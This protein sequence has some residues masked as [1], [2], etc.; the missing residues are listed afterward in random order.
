MLRCFLAYCRNTNAGCAVAINCKPPG[1]ALEPLSKSIRWRP[2]IGE[3]VGA[4]ELPTLA[5]RWLSHTKVTMTAMMVMMMAMTHTNADSS[6]DNATRQPT[7]YLQA[8]SDH[9]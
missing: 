6:R 9:H 2:P 8:T 4:V 1:T 7:H 5:R 3:A